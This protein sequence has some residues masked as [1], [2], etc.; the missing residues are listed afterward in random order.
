M[1]KNPTQSPIVHGV[2]GEP[3]GRLLIELCGRPQTA[4][5]LADRVG[6]SSNA[7]R[8]HLEG[9]RA[10][11]LVEYEVARR[12]V[13]KPT[14]V[15]SLTSA[16]Q[17][18]LSSAYLPTL[19]ALLDRLHERLNGGFAPLLRDVGTSW[20]QR[21]PRTT[22]PGIESIVDALGALG[23]PARIERDGGE[24]VIR[25]SCCPLAAVTRRTPEVC[26]L[27]EQFLTTASG[28]QVR[29][30]C[31]RT[32]HPSC[33]FAVTSRPSATRRLRKR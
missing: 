17:Y 16:A 22:K 26:Q 13:G 18:L 12:G 8:V 29:E 7:V 19:Q 32:T 6:T 14:H 31:E 5:E 20:G 25:N 33:A 27:V 11:G 3:R 1:A 28:V 10:A 9:L 21:A 4:L 15:Y 2:L 30:R 23:A 24:E